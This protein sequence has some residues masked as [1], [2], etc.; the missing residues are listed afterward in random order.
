[1]VMD[2][3]KDRIVSKKLTRCVTLGA[4]P[5]LHTTHGCRSCVLSY[6]R[7]LH[8]IRK[9]NNEVEFKW[10]AH[11]LLHNDADHVIHATQ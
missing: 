1:M 5:V 8:R 3:L 11:K 6:T 4:V 10:I 9:I 7:R 2:V